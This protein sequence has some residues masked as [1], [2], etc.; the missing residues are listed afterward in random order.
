MV[1][2]LEPGTV[3]VVVGGSGVPRGG[4]VVVGLTRE[5]ADTGAVVVVVGAT[6]VVTGSV[7]VVVVEEEVEDDVE[8]EGAEVD[9][10]DGGAGEVDVDPE[11]VVVTNDPTTPAGVGF[12]PDPEVRANS[13]ITAAP[14][15]V[16]P[17]TS[18]AFM[19]TG[20]YS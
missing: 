14:T 20:P 10:D 4:L 11:R 5:V 7:V 17:A 3:E 13:V 16:A 1:V 18:L 8:V 6:V 12:S 9:V 19:L 15:R 2:V